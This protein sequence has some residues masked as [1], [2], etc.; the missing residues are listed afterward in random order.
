MFTVCVGES[1]Q[2]KFD[3]IRNKQRSKLYHSELEHQDKVIEEAMA[4]GKRSIC[5]FFN[6]PEQKEYYT[7]K[8]NAPEW[9]E[10]F[11]ESAIA[12][13]EAN[14]YKINGSTISW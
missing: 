14:G 12:Q 5:F 2:E 4:V 3:R 11:R 1:A 7:R 8:Y 13:Y 6:C 9:F 10:Y